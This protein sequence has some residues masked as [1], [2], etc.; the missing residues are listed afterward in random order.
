[1][2][3]LK[4]ISQGV[5]KN[6]LP[7]ESGSQA[8][9]WEFGVGSSSFPSREAGAVHKLEHGNQRICNLMAVTQRAG[10]RSNG[11]F[12]LSETIKILNP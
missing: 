2:V 6:D 1:M 3:K 12:R 10:T 8:G 9:A 4:W 7:W 11:F 5:N